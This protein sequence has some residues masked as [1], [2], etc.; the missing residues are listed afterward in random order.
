MPSAGRVLRALLRTGRR[1]FTLIGIV[2]TA[3]ILWLLAGWPI[4]IDGWLNASQPPEPAEVIVCL[5]AGTTTGNLPTDDGWRRI[6]TTVQLFL[7]GFAPRVVF[8]GGGSARVSEAEAYAA[9]GRWMGIPVDVI[10]LDVGPGST[11][12][13]PASLLRGGH[14]RKDARILLVTSPM[15]SRRTLAVFRKQGFTRVRIVTNWHTVAAAAR[16]QGPPA[17]SAHPG[18]VRSEKKYD[19]PLFRLRYRVQD[20]LIGL[21]EVAAITAYWWRDEL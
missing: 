9:A 17:A 14:V 10:G 16:I 21:R 8:S 4:G 15:H 13:H 11:A 12:E 2:V 7:D 5:A 6:H 3:I 18:F 20:L 19:D 1:F